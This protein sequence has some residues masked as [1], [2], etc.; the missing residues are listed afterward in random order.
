MEL[1]E[2]GNG[3][4]I[5]FR[6]MGELWQSQHYKI[7]RMTENGIALIDEPSNKLVFIS[8]LSNVMQFELDSRFQNYQPNVH[9]SV[10]V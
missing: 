6:Q 8:E 9:Y 7:L 5:R 1:A 10:N 3:V 4:C 2:H